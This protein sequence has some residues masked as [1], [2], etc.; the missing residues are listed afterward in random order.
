MKPRLALLPLL[1][2][3]LS[4]LPLRAQVRVERAEIGF[5]GQDQELQSILIG[6]V[7]GLDAW[8]PCEVVLRNDGEQELRG[9]LTLVERAGP[10]AKRAPLRYAHELTLGPG[11]RKRLRFTVLFDPLLDYELELWDEGQAPLEL[12]GVTPGRDA[13]KPALPLT[14]LPSVPLVLAVRPKS[15]DRAPLD[16]YVAPA[17]VDQNGDMGREWNLL[18]VLPATLPDQAQAYQRVDLVLLDDLPLAQLEREQQRSLLA[19]VAEGGVLWVSTLRREPGQGPLAEA[20]PGKT[21]TPRDLAEVPSL[22]GFSVG[23]CVLASPRSLR[24]FEPRPAA[25]LWSEADAVVCHRRYGKGLIVQAGFRLGDDLPYDGRAM[26]R[27]LLDQRER[28][29]LGAPSAYA[30]R[31]R[32]A[33]ARSLHST[34]RKA[35]PPFRTALSFVALYFFVAVVL[36]FSL[37]H[38][39]GRRELAWLAVILLAIVGTGGVLYLGLFYEQPTRAVRV[40]VALGSGE[41]GPR[42]R[43]NLW[44]VFSRHGGPLRLTLPSGELPFPYADGKQRSGLTWLGGRQLS[45]RTFPQDTSL[46][47]SSG[48]R[49]QS[50]PLRFWL[51]QGEAR[52]EGPRRGVRAAWA[53]TGKGLELP[54]AGVEGEP[55]LTP[56]EQRTFGEVL[57]ALRQSTGELARRHGRPTLLYWLDV[58]P[59]PLGDLPEVGVEL[60]ILLG[61]HDVVADPRVAFPGREI[62]TPRGAP[63]STSTWHFRSR[64]PPG[65]ELEYVELRWS[66]LYRSR[67]Q[68]RRGRH[69][70]QPLGLAWGERRWRALGVRTLDPALVRVSPLGAVGAVINVPDELGIRPELWLHLKRREQ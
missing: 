57:A 62:Q 60:G 47:T 38:R 19:W 48:L 66:E 25:R 3:A 68:R 54:L 67:W 41:A 22:N 24:T 69:E 52:F 17:Q 4:A 70:R 20:L 15:E 13:T 42:L 2:V 43:T 50:E 34:T 56:A 30:N 55:E 7:T 1:L 49:H 9:Q 45:L 12:R 31:L 21:L 61:E 11:T 65:A 6:A 16:R 28:P 40:G 27:E 14:R 44:A 23:P 26:I 8:L 10:H 5:R 18:E 37:T 33:L 35:V 64:L 46:F 32:D 51:E 58:D 63:E 59:E 36:P 39:S 29:A 53:F